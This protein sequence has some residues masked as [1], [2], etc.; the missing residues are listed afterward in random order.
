M[1]VVRSYIA[2][3]WFAPDGGTPV[4]DAAT[5]EPVAEVSG[6]T[7]TVAEAVSA[8]LARVVVGDPGHVTVQGADAERGAFLSPIL[9]QANDARRPSTV[10]LDDIEQISPRAGDYGEV[11]WDAE[12]TNQEDK[13]VAAYDVLTMVAREWNE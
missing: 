10:T 13:V 3:R 8:E 6:L 2:G 7:E 5:G 11:R 1:A 9:L 4:Y 12:I